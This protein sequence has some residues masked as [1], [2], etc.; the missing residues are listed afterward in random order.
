MPEHVH[1][2]LLKALAPPCLSE[3]EYRA[4]SQF[5]QGETD[6]AALTETI[7][8]KLDALIL[9]QAETLGWRIALSPLVTWRFSVWDFCP[10]GPQLFEQYGKACA[11][12]A[13]YF[14]RKQSPPIADPLLPQSKKKTVEELDAMLLMLHKHFSQSR[15]P[16]STDALVLQ[17]RTIISDSPTAFLYLKPNLESWSQYIR[18]NSH[19]VK[20]LVLSRRRPAAS[21]FDSWGGWSTLRSPETFR[22]EVSKLAGTAPGTAP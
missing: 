18:E 1:E 12:S 17:F 3:S 2:E 13:R 19:T 4:W 20:H 6:G 8:A 9:H 7:F 22:Q 16:I 11:R 15:I 21:L 10:N 14:Q 5:W